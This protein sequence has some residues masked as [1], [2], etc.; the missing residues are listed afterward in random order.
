MVEDAKQGLEEI[1]ATIIPTIDPKATWVLV[2]REEGIVVDIKTPNPALL[3]GFRGYNL[4]ALQFLLGLL[5]YQRTG[6]WWPVLVDVD[7]WWQKREHDL[8]AQAQKLAQKAKFS[9]KPQVLTNLSPRERRLIHLT[10][11]SHPDVTTQSQG[12][13]A[14]RQLLIIP[15]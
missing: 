9:R 13:G 12:E 7:G 14:N 8:I 1:I 10:L 11:A 6:Q 5:L 3:I 15:K 2:E 4:Q